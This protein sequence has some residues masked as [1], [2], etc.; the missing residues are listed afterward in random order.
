MPLGKLVRSNLATRKVRTALTVGA[1]ALAVSLVVAVTSG[2]KS[3]EG[4]ILKYLVTYMGSTDVQVTDKADFRA[5]VSED[6]VTQIRKDPAVRLAVGRLE[7]DTGLIDAAGKP[8]FG[9]AAQ[10]IGVDRPADVD[11]VR[12][13][14]DAGRWFDTP[15]GDV[16]VIDQQAAE[17]LKVKLG[18]TINLPGLNGNRKFTVVGICHKP[19]IL[20]EKISWIYLP[21]RTCQEL[22][23]RKGQITRI[24]IQLSSASEDRAFAGRWEPRL[25]AINRD[26]TL[27]LARDT[28]KELDKNLQ[29]VH[30]LSF[31][32]GAVSIIVA[33]FIVFTTLSMGVTERQRTLAMLRAVGA[34]RTQVARMVMIESAYIGVAGAIVG[35]LLG[36][37]WAWILVTWKS[38]FFSAG[39]M[40]D[41]PAV[42]IGVGAAIVFSLIASLLPAWLASRV[43]PL[44]ALTPQARASSPRLTLVCA[45]IGVCLIAIDTTFIYFPGAPREVRYYGHFFLGLPGLMIGFFLLAPLIVVIVE[46]GLARVAARLMDVQPRLL[47]HQLSG[48]IWRAA[49]TGAALMVGLAILV[50]MQTVG[51][52][53]LMGW[54][55]PDKF[56]DIFIYAGQGLTQD[57]WKKLDDVEGIKKGEVLPIALAFPGLPEGLFGVIGA[58]VL[59]DATMFLGVDPDL[60]LQMME[61]EFRDGNAKDAVEGLKKGDHIIVTDEF[62]V[63]KGL[64]VGDS[65][66]LMTKNGMKPFKICGVI[67]SPGIDVMV[68]MFDMGRMFDQRTAASV[69]GSI[70]DAR[71]E[72]GKDKAFLFAANL[73]PGVD[74]EVML[75]KVKDQLGEKGWKA[76]DVRKI[77]FEIVK[78]FE[79][80]LLLLSTV[81]FA[82]M[83]VAALGVTNTVMASVRSRQ[84]QF[85]ILRSIGVTRG[86]LLRLVLAEA[87]LLGLV[88]CALGLAAG[89]LF[90]FNALGLSR[91][92]LGYVPDLAPPWSMVAAGA[93]ILMGVSLLA[94][95]WPAALVAR[96]QPLTLLQSGRAAI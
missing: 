18:D 17:V 70:D 38:D 41:W 93:A 16:A 6:L 91:H 21:L 78:G 75:K 14:V 44:E 60:A 71:K 57:Q 58:A 92:L 49:G 61:L 43:S 55:L 62:R 31:S 26:L 85:G 8:V 37:L 29:G 66:P 39:L 22:T 65:L 56:P 88:G 54:R 90:S 95:L 4:A 40:I 5:G 87:L 30:Y 86:Q 96:S 34:Q 81:A 46:A 83:A 42:G 33:A 72:F 79:K 25:K 77:K 45:A 32:G 12:T 50:A 67:W 27:R 94:S 2:Y 13:P 68:T 82:A 15:T 28:R 23:N 89:F 47:R 20:A 52:S 74:K 48:G 84:W 69:F 80:L 53:M 19:A 59:P 35:V 7:T 10:L 63:L 3:A 24:L 73:Q 36:I 9:R 51:H 64:K 11:I 76:G 1:I